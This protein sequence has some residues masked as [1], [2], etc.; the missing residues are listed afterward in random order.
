V[1]AENLEKVRDALAKHAHA[2]MFVEHCGNKG[3]ESWCVA[4]MLFAGRKLAFLVSE[5]VDG[6]C[7][8][9]VREADCREEPYKLLK[10]ERW[11]TL[12]NVIYLLELNNV[13]GIQSPDPIYLKDRHG[14]GVAVIDTQRWR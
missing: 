12:A 9:F 14:N 5:W 8:L 2:V 13:P 6:F 7:E 4:S 10:H 11:H 1:A 3:D